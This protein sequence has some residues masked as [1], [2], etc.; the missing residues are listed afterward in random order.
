[1]K[2]QFTLTD[3]HI[4]QAHLHTNGY[5]CFSQNCKGLLNSRPRLYC[6]EPLSYFRP[7]A[8]GKSS[9]E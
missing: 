7:S 5:R 8:A 1:M 2:V 3:S 4:Q 6:Y 9:G